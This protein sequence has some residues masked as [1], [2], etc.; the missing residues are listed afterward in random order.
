MTARVGDERFH[1]LRLDCGG[2]DCRGRSSRMLTGDFEVQEMSAFL[3]RLYRW[4]FRLPVCIPG[5]CYCR[6]TCISLI[7]EPEE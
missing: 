5:H 3:D 7:Q 6:R 4:L 2:L 1:V